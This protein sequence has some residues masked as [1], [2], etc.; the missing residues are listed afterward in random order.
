MAAAHLGLT[1]CLTALLLAGA[2][3]LLDRWLTTSPWL[4][5]V[6][7]LTGAAMGMYYV[8]RAVDQM[9]QGARDSNAASDSDQEPDDDKP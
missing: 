2:G 5:L 6:G 3:Y 1:V 7:A 4:M 9:Q 8:V